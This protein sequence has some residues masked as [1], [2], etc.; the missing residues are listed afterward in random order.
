MPGWLVVFGQLR[1]GNRWGC[2]HALLVS[3]LSG[4]S[5]SVSA[6]AAGAVQVVRQLHTC[7]SARHWL[8]S[9]C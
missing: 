6:T 5:T 7:C 3:M 2:S 9:W 8:R 1:R 4:F